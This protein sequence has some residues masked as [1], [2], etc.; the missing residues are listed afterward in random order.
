MTS[1]RRRS[2]QRGK[3]LVFELS[4]GCYNLV[5]KSKHVTRPTSFYLQDFN[6]VQYPS[7]NQLHQT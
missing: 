7:T 6:Y 1:L 5:S 3:L 4:G 2:V